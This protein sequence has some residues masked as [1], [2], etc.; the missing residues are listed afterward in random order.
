MEKKVEDKLCEL[1]K[2]M[3]IQFDTK[4]NTVLVMNRA[5][6]KIQNFY[7]DLETFD[8]D[9]KEEA[10]EFLL[11]SNDPNKQLWGA[12][13]AMSLGYI[14]K[15]E[16]AF[17]KILA[18]NEAAK[19]LY[20][21]QTEMEVSFVTMDGKEHLRKKIIDYELAQK[22]NK[23]GWCAFDAKFALDDIA[24]NGYTRMVTKKKK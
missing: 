20:E 11:N 6:R 8:Q 9:A 7:D 15:G 17:Y 21:S 18:D 19:L 23:L 1:K 12:H 13:F 3:A 4:N 10:I 22:Y 24:R 2:N 5:Y 14:E 16:T